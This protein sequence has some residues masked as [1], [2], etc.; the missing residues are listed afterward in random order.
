MVIVKPNSNSRHPLMNAASRTLNPTIKETPNT[1][2]RMVAIH[3]R[4]QIV[5]GGR[6][7]PVETSDV[8]NEM[9]EVAASVVL[10][11]S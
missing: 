1:T 5:H 2:S 6:K 11:P 3:A 7:K 9:I 4:C 10:D 8:W